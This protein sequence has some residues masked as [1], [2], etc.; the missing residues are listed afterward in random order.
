MTFE[1]FLQ[2]QGS[3]LSRFARP[4]WEAMDLGGIVEDLM[5]RGGTQAEVML[6]TELYLDW[7][8]RRA[9]DG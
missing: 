4:G 6:L 3:S 5:E 8:D 1:E 9:V 2:S 7:E